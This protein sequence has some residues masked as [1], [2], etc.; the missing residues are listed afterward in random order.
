MQRNGSGT[1]S[2][3]LAYIDHLNILLNVRTFFSTPRRLPTFSHTC[4]EQQGR[5]Q[6]GCIPVGDREGVNWISRLPHKKEDFGVA[7]VLQLPCQISANFCLFHDF[8]GLPQL[9]LQ[10]ICHDADRAVCSRRYRSS[11][12]MLLVW[13]YIAQGI[14]TAEH[15]ILTCRV[16]KGW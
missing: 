11:S 13:S 7:N 9:S 4:A 5:C 14:M 2:P 1:S 8:A 12:C 6:S 10:S 15:G 16:Q 3:T